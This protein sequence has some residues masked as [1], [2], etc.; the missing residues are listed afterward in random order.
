[1][2]VPGGA[3]SLSGHVDGLGPSVCTC[4]TGQAAHRSA[5]S[6][7]L[8]QSREQRAP[9]CL[10]RRNDSGPPIVALDGYV[11][12]SVCVAGEDSSGTLLKDDL[13]L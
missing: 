3:P 9:E 5:A 4:L 13:K 8:Q 10:V 2:R 11:R 12:A 1:M 7:I 6:W